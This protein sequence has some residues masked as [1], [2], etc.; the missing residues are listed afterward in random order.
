MKASLLLIASS[1][2]YTTV[3]AQTISPSIPKKIN[4]QEKYLFYFHGAVVSV[5]GD[6]AINNGAPEWGPY[7]YSNILD[8]LRKRGFNVISE[9]RNKD[10]DDSVYIHKVTKQVDSLLKAGA[11]VNNIIL[12]GASA[13]W[14]IVLHASAKLK[15]NNLKFVIMGG[16]WPDTYKDYTQL[17]LHGKFLS[18]FET[19]D[20]HQSCTMIF[21]DR[22]VQSFQEIKLNTGLSHGFFYKGRRVW[23]DPIVEWFEKGHVSQE[24]RTYPN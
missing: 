17:T 23:I 3:M 20:P 19:S 24:A 6:N 15:N 5:L 21:K 12:V 16:C 9:I 22:H 18:I 14:N 4:K 10:A 11:D 7:E 13:G 1:L 8:S 2:V